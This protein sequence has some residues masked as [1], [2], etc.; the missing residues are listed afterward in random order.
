M[1]RTLL[2]IPIP[3]LHTSLPIYSYG[4]M[5]MIAFLSG[6]YVARRLSA[7]HP[8]SGKAASERID[9]NIIS[10]ISIYTIIAAIVG[11]RLFFVIQNF[12]D[13]RNNPLDIF[14]IYQGGLVFYGGLIAVTI[15]LPVFARLKRISFLKLMDIIV[16]A[17]SLG[18]VFGRIGCFLN[19]CCYG[20]L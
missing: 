4:F 8:L 7:H 13:Y 2:E 6:L 20:K 10:D 12:S 15:A 16:I 11:A 1:R 9:P 18:L 14:K 5:L 19:G 17:T 3:F